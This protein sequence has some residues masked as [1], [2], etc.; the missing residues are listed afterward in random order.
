MIDSVFY[1]R[2]ILLLDVVPVDPS[3][4]DQ[5]IEPPYSGLYDG[6]ESMTTVVPIG[7]KHLRRQMDLG[8]REL[9]RQTRVDRLTVS[10]SATS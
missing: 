10:T 2:S 4:T 5:W 3:T 1:Y 6:M 9:R 7:D 8:Q